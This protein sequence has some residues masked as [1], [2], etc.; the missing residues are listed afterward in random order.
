MQH[1]PVYIITHRFAD[2]EISHKYPY[3]FIFL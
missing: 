1:A 2:K 3:E